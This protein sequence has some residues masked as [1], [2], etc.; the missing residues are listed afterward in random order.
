MKKFMSAAV[1]VI[2]IIAISVMVYTVVH[3][4]SVNMSRSQQAYVH[5]R[6][7]GEFK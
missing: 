2:G 6:S 3:F 4:G 5:W 1:A 7:T